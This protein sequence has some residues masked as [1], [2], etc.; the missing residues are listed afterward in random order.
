VRRYLLGYLK[1]PQWQGKAW[2]EIKSKAL[3]P[4]DADALHALFASEAQKIHFIITLLDEI[5][6]IDAAIDERVL[7]LYGIMSAVDRQRILGSAPLEED[8]GDV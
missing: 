8:E 2:D 6:H 5:R 7:D 4:E 3:I 1:R